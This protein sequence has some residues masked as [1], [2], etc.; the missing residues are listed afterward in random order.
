M[1]TT[2]P[3]VA[4]QSPGVGSGHPPVHPLSLLQAAT[5][6]APARPKERASQRQQLVEA[7]AAFKERMAV[8]RAYTTLGTRGDADFML[9][10]VSQR[11]EDFQELQSAILRTAL[12]AHLETPTPIWP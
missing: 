3:S 10:M 8:L 6:L 9:W 4:P 1:T 12:G 5:H 2:V 7:L 11:L